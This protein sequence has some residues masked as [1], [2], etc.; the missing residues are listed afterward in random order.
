MRSVPIGY[1]G[2][3][4]PGDVRE[5]CKERT[6]GKYVKPFAGI[7]VC[8]A[9]DIE[10]DSSEAIDKADDLPQDLVKVGFLYT[11]GKT[12]HV[13]NKGPMHRTHRVH[14]ETETLHLGI[15]PGSKRVSDMF[16]HDSYIVVEL[17]FPLW[18]SIATTN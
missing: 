16:S 6:W 11:Q 17:I 14:S 3:G 2:L 1:V 5:Q 12:H 13:P 8:E 18:M 10:R 9:L 15:A 7:I 4:V